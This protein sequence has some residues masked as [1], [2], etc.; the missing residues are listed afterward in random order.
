MPRMPMAI[1]MAFELAVYGLVTGL[2]I[3]VFKNININYLFKVIISLVIAMILGRITY[4]LAAMVFMESNNFIVVFLGTF[5][6]S[7]IGII[8]QLILIPFLAVRLKKYVQ[9]D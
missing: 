2:F 5:S 7:F 9:N 1:A 6:S 4:A 3:K 8:L